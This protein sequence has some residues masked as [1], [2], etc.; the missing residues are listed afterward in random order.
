[1]TTAFVRPPG[2][3]VDDPEAVKGVLRVMEARGRPVTFAEAAPDLVRAAADENDPVFFWEAELAVLGRVLPSWDQGQVGT[4]VSFGWG[5]G[6]Q[7]RLLLQ[8]ANGEAEQWP[9][10]E[11]AT[12][13]IYGGSRVEVGG[14]RISGDGSIG[15]WASQWCTRWGNL[16]RKPYGAHD[17]SAYSESRSRDWGR[18]GCP[19]DLEPEARLHPVRESVMVQTPDEIWAA[20]GAWKPVPVCSGRGFTSTLSG[21]F[22]EPSGS[23]AHCMVFRG[24]FVSPRRGKSVVIQN[25][26]GGYLKGDPWA[27]VTWDAPDNPTLGRLRAAG[28]A[29]AQGR[30]KLPEGC[31]A[32]T[33]EVAASMCREKDSFAVAGHKGWEAERIDWTP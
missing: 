32:T 17:L 22:C 24:R 18:R 10:A 30:V 5:R 26:W 14:G 31:F 21:G 12:E 1:V 8:I 2:G 19:D 33:L 25:S 23:W 28:W 16:L 9:G 27:E 13:P 7:D 15:A 11:V 4:C 29:D 6:S 20:L 3:W